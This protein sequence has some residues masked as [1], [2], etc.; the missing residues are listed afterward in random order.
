[1]SAAEQG[2]AGPDDVQSPTSPN[3]PQHGHVDE[4]AGGADSSPFEELPTSDR[5]PN[6]PDTSRRDPAEWAAA[7]QSPPRPPE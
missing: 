3:G 4:A 2:P 6:P 1:M 5:P 7:G